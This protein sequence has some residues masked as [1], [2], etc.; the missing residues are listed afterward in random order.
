MFPKDQSPGTLSLASG[1][2]TP[3][4][5]DAL[6]SGAAV[7]TST[8]ATV[9]AL[10]TAQPV[11]E[12]AVSPSLWP[13]PHFRIR[14]VRCGCYL[15]NY[16]PAGLPLTTY[17][18]TLRVEC[19]S[20]G[21]TASGDLY[22]RRIIL[23]PILTTPAASTVAPSVSI[24]APR[25]ILGPPPNPAAGIPIL[26]RDRYRYY[27][28]ITQILEGLTIANSF[29]LGFEMHRFNAV[30]AT[31]TNEG[32]FTALMTWT[33]APAGYPSSGD[34][35]AGDVKNSG[36]TVVGRLTMGW[37]S[38]YLR[39]ATLEIDRVSASEAPLNNG[40]GV[41][42]KSI[43]DSVGWDLTVDVSDANV[44]EPSGESWSNAECHAAMLARR[45][46]A[47]LDAEWRYHV[48]CVRRLDATE[49]GI[50]YDNGATDS[51]RVPR[52][53]CAIS[54]HWVI[55]NT[56]TWGLVRG[57][58]FGA[59]TKPYF[60]TAV[61]ETG[62]A[63][64][65]YHN[66]ADNGFLN[67]TDVIAASATPANPFPNNILWAYAPDDQKRLRHMPD[68]YVR[69]GGTPFG[70]SYGTTPISPTDQVVD[71][72]DLTLKVEPL[73]AA[74]PLG[75]PVR[76]NL[77]L[78][79]GGDLPV[80]A[81][82]R[83]TLGAGCVRGE[84]IDPSGVRR[85]FSPLVLCVDDQTLEPLEAKKDRT[86]SITLLRGREGALFPGP[87]LYTVQV[88][89]FWDVEGNEVVVTGGGS[90]MVTSAV[91][92]AHGEAA[93]KVLATP[94]TL[95]T[96]ALGGD[97]L[98]EGQAA[99][100]HALKNPVLRPHYAFIEAKRLATRFGKRK[101]DLKAAA[102][103]VDEQTIMSPD[104]LRKAATI[105]KAAGDSAAAKSL[106]KVLKGKVRSLGGGADLKSAV[107]GL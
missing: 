6:P 4:L 48:L 68:I 85:S 65:L 28:R 27:L 62:H 32:A 84:V 79:N 30:T 88:T 42:W 81:P 71:A 39:K 83:L 35:L 76:V 98:E 54:S 37:I 16:S 64:G 13:V 56:A 10:P 78:A 58:R 21:R 101:G 15:I 66:T 55:P 86:N 59:A 8:A 93:L 25:V 49:R 107:D 70:T 12:V 17:D 7:M 1:S 40:S 80:P 77:T 106:G 103:I 50:M 74:V 104:E 44:V 11:A 14:S 72:H 60:R 19:H 57:M 24:L 100:Q 87:G 67:T 34:Y 47:N 9:A 94:D 75:A 36:G 102:E 38:S 43:G 90:L 2:R 73:L 33:P 95:L 46:A 5:P 82:A 51:N 96:L 22:Q 3:P 18:G 29:T 97:H 105:T 23:L 69:P 52:E 26:P 91:D 89:V 53:G 63:M 45:D 61:H 92:D 41:D 20:G 99:I 31:W